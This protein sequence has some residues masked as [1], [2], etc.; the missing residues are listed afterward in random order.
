MLHGSLY[1]KLPRNCCG[2]AWCHWVVNDI[3][4]PLYT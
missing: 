3:R 1:D 2:M 4:L